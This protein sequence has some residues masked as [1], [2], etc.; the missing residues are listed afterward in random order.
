MDSVINYNPYNAV[1]NHLHYLQS[2]TYNPA[3][4]AR[5]LPSQDSSLIIKRAIQLKQILDGKGYYLDLRL[6]PNDP[7]Y[8]DSLSNTSTYLLTKNE[9]RIYLE[10]IGD[11]W[12]Y[13]MTT[14][15]LIPKMHKEVFPFGTNL[16]VNL[17][18]NKWKYSFAGIQLW[19]WIGFLLLIIIAFI[20]FKI[21]AYVLSHIIRK[22]A[23]LQFGKSFI[24]KKKSL[25]AARRF[26]LFFT[27]KII[28]ILIPTLLLHP[29]ISF[30]VFTVFKILSLSFL[31]LFILS[32]VDIVV[33]YFDQYAKKTHSTLDNQLIPVLKKLTKLFIIIG[34]I[35]FI[36]DQ[37]NVNVTALLAG[38]SIGGL[39]IALAAQDTVKNLFGSLMIFLD[40][41]FQIGDAINFGGVS[42]TVE[43][44]GIRSTR[45]RT[46]TNSLTSIPNGKLTDMVVDNLGLRVYRRWKT[47]IGINYNTPPKKIEVF[48]AGIKTLIENQPLTKKEDFEVHLNNFGASALNILLNVYFETDQWSE[49]LKG[50]H[51]L[52]IGIIKLAD[53][54]NIDFAFP[55]TTVH[56]EKMPNLLNDKMD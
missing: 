2:E 22:A 40:K 38:I 16:L 49:E 3:Q 20:L 29:K 36:L 42:G 12:Q 39:A 34:G 41:P 51:D 4:S 55:T 47:E 53:S 5:S 26:S 33:E 45:I 15:E 24:H 56:I 17:L 19:Q 28:S 11:A 54:L 10:K 25:K 14:Y 44:V 48:I 18:S 13:S 9:P 35:I 23:D 6:I 46:F 21:L 31:V 8:K 1:H 50:R 43:E 30:Y 27:A 52:M 37:L 7:N 32:L